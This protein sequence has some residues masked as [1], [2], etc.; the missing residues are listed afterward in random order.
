MVTGKPRASLLTNSE[1]TISRRVILF[2]T[3]A[4]LGSEKT[5]PADDESASLSL[6]DRNS[7]VKN[8]TVDKARTRRVFSFSDLEGMS[9]WK[10][11]RVL[12]NKFAIVSTEATD[13]RS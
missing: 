13:L 3:S 5:G 4:N 10:S 8:N 12:L 6:Y 9:A 7:D 1:W 2:H 11:Q